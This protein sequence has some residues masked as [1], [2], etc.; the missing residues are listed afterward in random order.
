MESQEQ[1]AT[2]ALVDSLAEQALLESLLEAS[3]PP[4]QPDTAGLHYLLATPFRYPPLRHGSRF[5]TRFEP[6]LFYASRDQDSALAETAYYRLVFWS[7]MTSP[8]PGGRL[9]TEHT[10]FGARIDTTKGLQLQAAPFDSY[11]DQLQHPADCAA[12][13]QLGQQLREA[14]IEAFEYRSARDPQQGINIALFQPRAFAAPAPHWQQTWLCETGE[15][16]VAFFSKQHGIR[17]YER[18][19]FL[20]A[21][22]LP[23]PAV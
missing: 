15:S 6:S 19:V 17:Q 22:E 7:G 14:G 1:I 5:G 13:Q 12:T 3:K 18:E 10:A 9:T 20:V 23:V 16:G 2:N 21:G 4:Q 8:P 11:A